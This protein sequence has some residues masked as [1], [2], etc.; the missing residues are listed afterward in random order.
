MS[1]SRVSIFTGRE[2]KRPAK[3]KAYGSRGIMVSQMPS[4]Y[5]RMKGMRN[6]QVEL[7]ASKLW[8]IISHWIWLCGVVMN[9]IKQ[10]QWG[11]RDE[12]LSTVN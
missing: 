6:S 5:Y 10:F 7:K 3:G 11:S 2:E 4:K 12:R 1:S 8:L 9:L